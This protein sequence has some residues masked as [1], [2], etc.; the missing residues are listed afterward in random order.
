[1][2]TARQQGLDPLAIV[3]AVTASAL[4]TLNLLLTNGDPAPGY[5]AAHIGATALTTYGTFRTAPH[6]RAALA[7]A[8][9]ALVVLGLLA[10]LSTGLLLVLAGGM[11]LLATSRPEPAPA[12]VRR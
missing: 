5:L 6:R 3:A 7:L 4:I 11:A 8:G 1:M 2:T 12:A 10:I 9:A